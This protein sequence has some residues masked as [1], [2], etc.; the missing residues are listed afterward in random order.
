MR[1]DITRTHLA[2]VVGDHSEG[3]IE[4]DGCHGATMRRF[5]RLSA[6]SPPHSASR[7]EVLAK[8]P[9]CFGGFVMFDSGPA[10]K[11]SQLFSQSR[12]KLSS[13]FSALK[14]PLCG[15]EALGEV[16]SESSFS[17]YFDDFAEDGTARATRSAGPATSCTS[18]SWTATSPSARF[19]HRPSSSTKAPR[20]R[21]STQ[22][23]TTKCGPPGV[24][25]RFRLRGSNL[26]RPAGSKQTTKLAKSRPWWRRQAPQ[27]AL[28]PPSRADFD[29]FCNFL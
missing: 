4:V 16:P 25:L 9:L 2:R 13:V 29:E 26:C 19:S 27:A 18:R 12:R 24:G 1:D 23:A 3:V 15:W 11:S 17:R 21:A 28:G 6:L 10:P 5:R 14:I 7:H 20:S 8:P 22:P